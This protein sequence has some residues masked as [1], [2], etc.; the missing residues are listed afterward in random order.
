MEEIKLV[1]IHNHERYKITNQYIITMINE[2]TDALQGLYDR[3][4]VSECTKYP[5]LVE[6]ISSF[7]TLANN[8]IEILNNNLREEFESLKGDEKNNEYL[9]ILNV[10][11]SEI[12][13]LNTQ[14]M[15]IVQQLLSDKYKVVSALSAKSFMM[16]VIEDAKKYNIDCF[17]ATEA[18]S[19]LNGDHSKF[20]AKDLHLMMFGTEM[21]DNYG[22][23]DPVL[24]D[25]T[26]KVVRK[27]PA[28]VDVDTARMRLSLADKEFFTFEDIIKWVTRNR[29]ELMTTTDIMR[30]YFIVATNVILSVR[31][32]NIDYREIWIYTSPSLKVDKIKP[33]AV[34]KVLVD[35]ETFDPTGNVSIM[36]IDNGEPVK[37]SEIIMKSSEKLNGIRWWDGTRYKNVFSTVELVLTALLCMDVKSLV[38]LSKKEDAG[39]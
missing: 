9:E 38:P 19:M 6:Y 28:K 34:I 3:Y 39:V 1:K 5:D 25:T 7:C 31:F 32:H 18:G 26:L 14:I 11:A 8:N 21:P 29:N 30:Y 36:A 37:E 17:I 4:S 24:S 2:I 22:K 13:K 33:F 12:G 10:L 15:Q 27:P 23:E 35:Q 16:K 20:H